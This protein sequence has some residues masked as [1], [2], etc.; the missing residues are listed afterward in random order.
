[1]TIKVISSELLQEVFFNDDCNYCC[2]HEYKKQDCL[3]KKSDNTESRTLLTDSASSSNCVA[4]AF[5]TSVKITT[6]L[7]LKKSAASSAEQ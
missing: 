6:K 4:A 3:K 2:R 7:K 5:K 1:M